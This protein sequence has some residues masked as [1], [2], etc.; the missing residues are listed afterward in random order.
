M[1]S[2]SLEP[3][4]RHPGIDLADALVI[5]HAYVEEHEDSGLRGIHAEPT[6]AEILAYTNN[7]SASSRNFL[8]RWRCAFTVFCAGQTSCDCRSFSERLDG[9][10][11]SVAPH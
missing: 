2:L 6:D 3:I 4:L 11:P 7:Q 1:T 8:P 9:L 10:A 5:R